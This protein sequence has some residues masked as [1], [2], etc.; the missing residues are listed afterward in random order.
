MNLPIP[1]PT[2][3]RLNRQT[4]SSMAAMRAIEDV[5]KRWDRSSDSVQRYGTLQDLPS[6]LMPDELPLGCFIHG[7]ITEDESRRIKR[8]LLKQNK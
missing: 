2:R 3:T 1:E 8:E 7:C 6:A 4:E 5:Y